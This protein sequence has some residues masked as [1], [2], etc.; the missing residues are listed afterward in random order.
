[1]SGLHPNMPECSLSPRP[2]APW[3][4]SHQL[5]VMIPCASQELYDNLASAVSGGSGR[6]RKPRN[7]P[8]GLTIVDAVATSSPQQ[9]HG[10]GHKHAGHTHRSSSGGFWSGISSFIQGRGDGEGGEGRGGASSSWPHLQGLYMYGGVGV[11]KTMLMDLFVETA[12]KEFQV[13]L[14][15]LTGVV[16]QLVCRVSTKVR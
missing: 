16:H 5:V 9:L 14:C 12:P 13:G 15:N 1:M 3:N 8:S 4:G 2:P 6:P 10:A 11:G 7:R